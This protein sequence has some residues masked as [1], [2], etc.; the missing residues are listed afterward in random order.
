MIHFNVDWV[1]RRRVNENL[2]KKIES[3][4]SVKDREITRLYV[5]IRKHV[6]CT[7]FSDNV[8]EAMDLHQRH[9]SEIPEETSREKRIERLS[10]NVGYKYE[11]QLAFLLPFMRE[12][13]LDHS[14]PVREGNEV[15]TAEGTPLVKRKDN[16]DLQTRP[17]ANSVA[18]ESSPDWSQYDE[19]PTARNEQFGEISSETNRNW[20]SRI[21]L[22]R[23]TIS[24]SKSR[25]P[26]LLT[27]S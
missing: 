3:E 25:R 23:A 26:T 19:E 6:L 15:L 8:Q 4:I 10:K 14:G 21:I 27:P 17:I 2:I 16:C 7:W 12:R 11:N 9:L 5:I 13:N 20:Q 1:E 24:G 18:M 22:W